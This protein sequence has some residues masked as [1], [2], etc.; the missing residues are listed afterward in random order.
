MAVHHMDVEAVDNQALEREGSMEERRKQKGKNMASHEQ[1]FRKSDRLAL[2]KKCWWQQRPFALSVVHANCFRATRRD[3]WTNL[4]MSAPSQGTP[5][6]VLGDF[7]A[8][9]QAHEK[10]GPGSF[11]LGS[12]AEFGAM[13][14]GC[15]LIQ[16]PSQGRKF[17]WTNNWRRGN[18]VAV[19]D[20]SFCTDDWFTVFKDCHQRKIKRLKEDIREWARGAFPNVNLEVHE[21]L[22]GLEEI[23]MEIEEKGMDDQLF[24][25]EAEAKSRHLKAME[26]YEKLW[27]E[28]ARSRWRLQGDR[29]S[30][31]FHI[32]EK[33]R[34]M[35]NTII[36]LKVGADQSSPTTDHLDILD[37]IAQVLEEANRWRLDKM[38]SNDE[39][40]GLI[41]E[42]DPESAPGLDGFPGML[43]K[44]CWE[45]IYVDVCN[46]VRGF[47]NR[48]IIPY[49]INTIRLLGM[50]PR[51]ISEEQGAFQKGKIIH[52]NI[53]LASELSDFLFSTSRGGEMGLKIDI[54]KAYDTISWDFMF[55]VL[56]KFGFS[57]NWISWVHQLLAFAKVSV[58]LNGGPI[59]YFGVE[60]GLRQGDPLSPLLFI[61]AEEVL[62]RGL[63]LL[64]ADMKIQPLKGPRGVI[65]PAH[66][67]FADDI[68]IFAN[69]SIRYVKNL[70]SFLS[71][72]QEFSGQKINLEK[73]KIFWGDISSQRKQAIVE[74]LGIPLCMF[75]TRYL[76]VEIFKGRIKKESVM[77]IM[78]RVKDRLSGWK[79]KLLSLTGRVELGEVDSMKRIVVNWDQCCKP[80]EEGGL[81]LRR[82]RDVN[83]AM[84]CKTAWKIK[85]EDSATSR[86]MRA[87]FHGKKGTPKKGY[88]RSS[89]RPGIKSVWNFISSKE[90]WIV[91]DGRSINFWNDIWVG[92]AA[93]E[94]GVDGADR[95]TWKGRCIVSFKISNGVYLRRLGVPIQDGSHRETLEVFWCKPFVNWINL[96]FDGSSLGNPGQVGVGGIFRDQR[97]R[98]LSSYKTFL[99]VIGAFEAKIEG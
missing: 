17:T 9:F 14:D 84:L 82:L 7:N 11:N 16:I 40:K 64:V 98:V 67:L 33:I 31:F 75:P 51:L 58:L 95:W 28:K 48:G 80:K 29:S 46:A 21:A 36:S 49:G 39:I 59:G 96:N 37:C 25:E 87:R 18:V 6:L 63:H 32:S 68:F 4:A 93:L 61:L 2:Q 12:V 34:R 79:G 38:P 19:L 56:R 86:F 57:E 72:Y 53:S 20:R 23:Q 13:V 24:D 65:T 42:L 10:R 77:P 90:R 92:E 78:D 71:K 62:C 27:V 81:G 45:I 88:G 1:T 66:S 55:Q 50:L 69:A 89:I 44:V 22:K 26:G 94:E 70:K 76:G 99:E 47:F 91:G 5:W 54:Q 60:R 73:S 74:E 15:S 41:W 83:K 35:K 43:H 52:S 30:K 85:H 8:T 97:G 3:L